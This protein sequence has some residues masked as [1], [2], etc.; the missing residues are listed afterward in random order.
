MPVL[1]NRERV[2]RLVRELD[3]SWGALHLARNTGK[4]GRG[5]VQVVVV[6]RDQNRR[7]AGGHVLEAFDVQVDRALDEP[8][9]GQAT[10]GK[11]G[12]RFLEGL[13]TGDWPMLSAP[14]DLTT[15]LDRRAQPT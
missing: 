9:R 1:I 7:T 11:R 8:A 14:P 3:S 2:W 13:A 6:A 15:S 5:I 10:H 4:D 12:A